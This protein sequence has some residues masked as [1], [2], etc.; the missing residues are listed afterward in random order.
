MKKKYIVL[1]M[2]LLMLSVT[3]IYIYNTNHITV[4]QWGID[5]F[6]QTINGV[7]GVSGV[8][9]NALGAWKITTGSENIII[10][11]LDTGIESSNEQFHES[12]YIN[13]SEIANNGIDDDNNG[14]IDDIN[15]WNFYDNTNV[16]YDSYL[17][18]Y[19]GTYIAGIIGSNHSNTS[20]LGVAP[21]VTIMPLK[22]MRGSS[23]LV[24]DAISAIEY[25]SSA[26]VKVINCSWDSNQYDEELKATIASHPE[27]LFVCSAG[28]YRNDLS[29]IPAYP[30]SFDLPN[31]ISVGA[32]DSS[33]ELY[34][35]SGFGDTVDV[36][37]PG[38]DILSVLPE[39]E[40]IYSKGT[41]VA[42]A[43]VSGI[44][45]LIFSMDKSL[46][47]E[48]VKSAIISSQKMIRDHIIV[49]AERALN[50]IEEEIIL[51]KK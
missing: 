43:Y 12:I 40:Y 28:K 17:S 38:E 24:E 50:I 23:G 9:I 41:S 42:T 27:I 25:A 20:M 15:G 47:T 44:A 19:H 48:E 1:I 30:A 21:D 5:N 10:G 51:S 11:I 34:M 22:F 6:G 37:A 39:G 33:N 46:S 2:L 18:D 16:I 13:T 36:Y 4:N 7:T 35:F 31:I 32:V 45:G 14:Y 26:G 8:D 49:D 29:N 3:M